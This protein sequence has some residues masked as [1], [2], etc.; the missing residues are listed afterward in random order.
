[1]LGFYVKRGDVI[2]EGGE[3]ELVA[4]GDALEFTASSDA[5]GYLAIISVDGARK[6]S[7][8][9]PAGALAAAIGAGR[10]QVLPLSVRLDGVLGVERV[11]G[12]F[13]D[14]PAAVESLAAAVARGETPT[15]CVVDTLTFE[16]R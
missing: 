9:Y 6:V 8:Y 10:A 14:H 5:P 12:V 16:K 2:R 11:A 1:V 7:V 3:G 4:P 15:G 13:C